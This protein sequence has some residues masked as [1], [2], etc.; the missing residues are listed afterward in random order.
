LGVAA[1]L[2]PATEQILFFSFLFLT[3]P[4]ISWSGYQ[5]KFVLVACHPWDFIL[6][7]RFSQRWHPKQLQVLGVKQQKLKGLLGML[8]LMA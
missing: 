3:L 4:C 1:R 7:W 2:P 5:S 6:F 8:Q